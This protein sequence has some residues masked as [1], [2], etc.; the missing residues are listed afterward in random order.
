MNGLAVSYTGSITRPAEILTDD[1]KPFLFFGTVADGATLAGEA[2]ASLGVA[3]FG[4]DVVG[5]LRPRD[6]SDRVKRLA[7]G[8]KDPQRACAIGA[9]ATPCQALPSRP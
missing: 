9:H 1:G 7:G 6:R 3:Y 8:T 2:A 4:P 5:M